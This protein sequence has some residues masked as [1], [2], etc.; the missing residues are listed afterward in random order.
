MKTLLVSQLPPPGYPEVLAAEGTSRAS[1]AGDR[2]SIWPGETP[3][4]R[5]ENDSE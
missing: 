3:D 1:A 4:D 2:V 5:V